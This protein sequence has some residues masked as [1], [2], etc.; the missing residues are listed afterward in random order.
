MVPYE[1]LPEEE[2]DYDRNTAM[3]T[4]KAILKMGYAIVPP[5]GNGQ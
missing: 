4:L 1:A 2:K 3:A 5:R